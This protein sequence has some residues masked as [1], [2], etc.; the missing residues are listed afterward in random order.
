MFVRTLLLTLVLSGCASSLCAQAKPA[1]P[2]SRPVRVRPHL[3][4]FDIGKAAGASPNQVGG[5]SRG[6]GDVTLYAPTVGKAYGL[7][8]AFCWR[9]EDPAAV[10]TFRLLQNGTTVYT[11]TVHGGTF[12]YPQDAP[13]LVPG[14]SYRWQ[15]APEPDLLGGPASATIVIVRGA[16]RDSVT[17]ALRA[18]ATEAKPRE[19]EARVSPTT[20]C[21]TT[22]SRTG[23]A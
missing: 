2:N 19:A 23:A 17:A 5:A 15:V 1:A 20:G 21:G 6:L 9:S 3:E 22:P 18:A 4:G 16:E 7:H 14:T 11:A 13:A 12:R 8:P 10:F